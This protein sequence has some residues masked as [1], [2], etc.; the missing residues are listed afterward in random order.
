MRRLLAPALSVLLAA[1]TGAQD[2]AAPAGAHEIIVASVDPDAMAGV[3]PRPRP[4][5]ACSG[6]GALCIAAASYDA[7]VCRAIEAAAG[8]SALDPHFF[9]RLIWRESLFDAGAVSP[10]GAEGIAQ[11]MPETARLRGLRDSFNP[12]EALLASAAYLADLSKA[13][14][15]IGLAAVAYNG[16]EAR[17]ERFVAKDGGLPLETRAYVQAITGYSAEIW[18]DAAPEKVDLAL[19]GEGGFQGACLTLAATRS[20]REFPTNGGA[21]LKAWGVVLASNRAR[22]GVER[23][24]DRLK[25][26]YAGLLAGE[27][28]SYSRNRRAGMP[29]MH[30]AQVGRD[31]RAEA[32]ALCGRLRAAGAD[33]MVLSN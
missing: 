33:C 5:P 30:V 21:P 27:E 13:Y 12:A 26:R 18:R 20:L 1:P 6:D 24:A 23:Q 15:N 9:A 4:A 17:A 28:F 8:A 14:G 31:S 10:A 32:N 2:I 11:F 29:R 3:A 25:N 7:D 19:K 16:G 22:E